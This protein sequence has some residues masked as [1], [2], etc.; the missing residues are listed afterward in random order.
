[1]NAEYIAIGLAVVVNISA[2]VGAHVRATTIITTLKE[3]GKEQANE[4]KNM[5]IRTAALAAQV[6]ELERQLSHTTNNMNVHLRNTAVHVDPVR[7]E[8]RWNDLVKRLDR[9]E[10][11][12]DTN[13]SS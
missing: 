8:L 2:I 9:I 4:V 13:Q 10:H 12:I 5:T 6:I 3:Q 1:M 7:D 11:K